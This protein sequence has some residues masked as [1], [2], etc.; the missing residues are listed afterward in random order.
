MSDSLS[1]APP[2]RSLVGHRE[3]VR[4]E[5]TLETVHQ[6]FAAGARDFMAVLEGHTLLGLCSRR[7]IGTLLGA[8]YGFALYAR[9]RVSEHLTPHPVVV[10][11]DAPMQEVLREIARR[12]DE[13]FYDDVLLVD[14]QGEFLGLI[15][16]RELVRVQHSL[17]A[18]NIEELGAR[19]RQMEEDLRM[20]REVQVALLPRDFPECRSEGGRALRFAQVFAPASGV[21]GDFFDVIPVS[22]QAAGLLM[23]DVMGHGVRSA[24]VTA[25]VRTMIEEVRGDAG[26]PAAF[27]T[28]LNASLTHL[29]QRTGD[30]IF[31]TACYAVVDVGARRLTFAHAG[32]PFPVLWSRRT[33]RAA[34]LD[35]AAR[36]GGPALGL[37]G[38]HRYAAT[39]VALEAGD[40][41]LLLTDGL[42][43]AADEA[44]QE[45]G[46][47]ALCRS[48]G[49]AGRLPLA[50][51]LEQLRAAA[52]EH[53]G[54]LG[55]ADDVCLLACELVD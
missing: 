41:L 31:V 50:T 9:A 33:G 4:S 25:M 28:R 27:L 10:R 29:L 36:I 5:E 16:V 2:L 22:D 21:S 34:A 43:E 52:A 24:L 26:D 39:D 3:F 37:M 35:A 23:C 51:A 18:G 15:H 54:G 6:R 30:L 49:T 45:F 11:S 12:R 14:P 42:I 40:R 44:G 32:H 19:N 46:L 13:H 47:E 20:A 17:L 38:E 7:E 53:T 48:F 8:R 55:F 1:L